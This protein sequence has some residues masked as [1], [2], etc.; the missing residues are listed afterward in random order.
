MCRMGSSKEEAR[1]MLW[2]QPAFYTFEAE[3]ESSEIT[4]L[5]AF[6]NQRLRDGHE[7]R[8]WGA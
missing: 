7:E 6:E 2:W 8:V 4:W 5:K 1:C 3:F